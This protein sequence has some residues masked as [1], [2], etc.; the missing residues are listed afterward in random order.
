MKIEMPTRKNLCIES[1]SLKI[2]NGKFGYDKDNQIS[3]IP[4][5]ATYLLATDLSEGKCI[6]I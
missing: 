4:L 1:I 2:C 3:T 5:Y 6:N